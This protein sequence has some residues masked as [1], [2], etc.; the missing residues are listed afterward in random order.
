MRSGSPSTLRLI[1]IALG[2]VAACE[3]VGLVAAWATQL[4]VTTWYPTLTKPGFTPPNWLF[5]PAWTVLYAMM[6]LAA[7]LV[8]RVEAGGGRRQRALVWFVVQ[9]GLNAG[10][11]FAFF[12]ARSPAFGLVVIV[13]L[14]GALAWTT[15][16]F[17]RTRAA[18]GWLMIPYLLWVTYAAALNA[19]IWYL[20]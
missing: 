7:F 6:G 10:W 17:F 16:R 14:W 9:L 12:G 15:D 20:N 11:S 5:A 8:W 2:F 3:A 19:G 18:A 4:S 13:A 1:L